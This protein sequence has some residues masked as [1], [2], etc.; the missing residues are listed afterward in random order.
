MD[1]AQYWECKTQASDNIWKRQ[2]IVKRLLSLELID[3]KVLEIGVGSATAASALNITFLANWVYKGT[4]VNPGVVE[5]VRKRHHLDIYEAEV[6]AL[7][8]PDSFFDTVIALDVL[9]H[10]PHEERI[11]GY[12]EIDR[13]LKPFGKIALN[14]PLTVSLHEEHEYGFDVQDMVTL[15]GVC[16]MDLETWETYQVRLPGETRAYVWAV[17]V[18]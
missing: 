15:L 7:P 16:R 4:D 10:V 18:R 5:K 14:I 17:G 13:V 6:I 12:E 2:A 9:E 3:Q 1:K 11:R 8:F